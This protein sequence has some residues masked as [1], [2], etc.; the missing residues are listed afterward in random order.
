[1]DESKTQ[2]SLVTTLVLQCWWTWI[3]N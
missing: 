3:I 2:K 1:V